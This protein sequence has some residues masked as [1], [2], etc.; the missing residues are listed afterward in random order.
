[1]L[2]WQVAILRV[3]WALN[4]VEETVRLQRP[5]SEAATAGV[6]PRV[7]E[8]VASMAEVFQIVLSTTR[9]AYK[10]MFESGSLAEFPFC[11]LMD[12]LE[13]QEEAISGELRVAPFDPSGSG[14][15]RLRHLETQ[16]HEAQMKSCFAVAWEHIQTVL[17]RQENAVAKYLHSRTGIVLF[18]GKWS[19]TSQDVEIILAYLMVHEHAMEELQ[20]LRAFPTV[21]GLMSTM[22]ETA[23][24]S[25]LFKIFNANPEMFML[26]EHVLAARLMVCTLR[27]I[28]D[29]FVED[30]LLSEE[31]GH[32]LLR[33]AQSL[34]EALQHYRPTREQRRLTDPSQ[35]PTISADVSFSSTGDVLGRM[36]VWSARQSRLW[37]MMMRPRRL[38]R[39]KPA[40]VLPEPEQECDQVQELPKRSQI[41]P[42]DKD[43]NLVYC[44]AP[45]G[46]RLGR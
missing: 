33:G 15:E 14:N 25:S 19:R 45:P 7:L 6:N 38:R 12:S 10:A 31:G 44:T 27:C 30:G 46:G 42:E 5:G 37:C 20:V 39:E 17:N 24:C 28:I 32:A 35:L 1:M 16:S 4:K 13:L 8:D 2:R 3:C 26:F 11:V 22:V 21:R 34:E 41:L 36:R 29:D 43:E 40:K 9:A 18:G 23:R